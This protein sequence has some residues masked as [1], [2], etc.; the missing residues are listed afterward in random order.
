MNATK[1][2]NN[3]SNSLAIKKIALAKGWDKAD[4]VQKVTEYV[5]SGS[6]LNIIEWMNE[7]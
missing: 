6:K 5:Y 2:I 7:A 3:T 1:I 4:R